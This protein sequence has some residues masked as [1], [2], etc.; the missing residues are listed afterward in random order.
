M[1]PT[2]VSPQPQTV[3]ATTRGGVCVWGGGGGGGLLQ[4][5]GALAGR[6]RRGRGARGGESRVRSPQAICTRPCATP[7]RHR[8]YGVCVARC[9]V[10]ASSEGLRACAVLVSR[11]V[12]AGF[13][14]APSELVP[15]GVYREAVGVAGQMIHCFFAA[16]DESRRVPGAGGGLAAEGEASE[17][18][19]SRTAGAGRGGYTPSLARVCG[20]GTAHDS[21]TPAISSSSSPRRLTSSTCRWPPP[22]PSRPAGRPGARAQA[23][24]RRR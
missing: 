12:Q 20:E 22:P 13:R 19:T 6:G 4:R 9:A 15:I 1:D 23:R 8:I 14:V 10:S 2:N 18:A 11:R 7:A 5:A 3:R 24:S 17:R 21:L 16:V